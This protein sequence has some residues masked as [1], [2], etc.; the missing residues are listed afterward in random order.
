MR[1]EQYSHWEHET[2]HDAAFKYP[3]VKNSKSM[4]KANDEDYELIRYPP[5]WGHD[6]HEHGHY[7]HDYFHEKDL[8]HAEIAHSQYD[9]YKHGWHHP[10]HPQ[11]TTHFESHPHQF[12][13]FGSYEPVYSDSRQYSSNPKVMTEEAPEVIYNVEKDKKLDEDTRRALE[14]Y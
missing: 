11:Q 13:H 2:Q 12:E 8:H 14:E 5:H 3:F 9:E 10:Q 6:H 7:G 4:S 1:P